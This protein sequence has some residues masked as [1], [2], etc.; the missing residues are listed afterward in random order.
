MRI[1]ERREINIARR[2]SNNKESQ[3]ERN[4][5]IRTDAIAKQNLRKP[6][7]KQGIMGKTKE[8]FRKERKK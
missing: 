1:Q 7:R 8:H 6:V 2:T 4:N 3:T 5:K